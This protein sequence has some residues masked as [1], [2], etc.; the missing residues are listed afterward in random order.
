MISAQR[1]RAHAPCQQS[2]EVALDRGGGVTDIG[3]VKGQIAIV[4]DRK[5]AQRI[6]PP[7]QN[8]TYSTMHHLH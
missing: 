2:L 5:L 1:H 7:K 4:D 3:I 8:Q 6:K